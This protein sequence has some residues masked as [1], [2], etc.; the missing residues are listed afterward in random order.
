[1]RLLFFLVSS[2]AWATTPTPQPDLT[3]AIQ[4][5]V[6][7]YQLPNGLT[8]L[9]QEDHSVPLVTYQQWFR[10]GS[11]DEETGHTG[12]AHFFEHMMFKGSTHY[13]KDVFAHELPSKGAEFNA[14]TSSDY[15]GYHITLPRE[16]L[17]LAI[18]LEAD[19]M[20]NLLLDP[21]DVKSEREVVKE[22]RRMRYDNQPE[23]II[24]ETMDSLLYRN[25]PYR[26]PTIG[27]MEDLNKASMDDLHAFYKRYYSPNN[28][29]VVVAGDFNPADV[30]RW[31]GEAYG[32]IG[33]EDFKRKTFPPEWEQKKPQE[34]T[35]QRNVQSPIYAIG[36]LTPAAN[37]P[38]TYALNLAAGV[39]AQGV[40]SRLHKKMVY[41]QQIAT[42]VYAGCQEE[43]LAGRCSFFAYLKPG[44]NSKV[45]AS[46]IAT[47]IQ[48]LVN[49][50]VSAKE[51]DKVKN[52]YMM[53]YVNALGTLNGRAQ[54]LAL[55]E[56]LFGD[57]KKLFTD[58]AKIQE[59]TP[60]DVQRV[61]KKYLKPDR[62]NTIIVIP[63]GK[64]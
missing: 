6:D 44:A 22:E 14:F 29:V 9:L 16:S 39:L 17:K 18:A 58:M 40:S 51:L 53:E 56:I 50:K 2:L 35:I 3:K 43:M 27:S 45:V 46:T 25:L 52:N 42:H 55:N 49:E 8:V 63:G 48:N 37:H 54:A 11:K 5:K 12:L 4:L 26:W 38:D 1:M 57:Y 10:V 33:P 31:I 47:E 59:V 24:H 62:K 13:S 61:T 32:A 28:A 30:K 20:R 21:N 41:E 34:K 15:T 64:A 36:Y 60:A 7:K 19:R 23:G